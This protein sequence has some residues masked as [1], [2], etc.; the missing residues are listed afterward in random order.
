MRSSLEMHFYRLQVSLK[1]LFIIWHFKNKKSSQPSSPPH[2]QGIA[3]GQSHIP[4][5]ENPAFVHK[6]TYNRQQVL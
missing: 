6:D 3:L 1:E 5:T 2:N 4:R